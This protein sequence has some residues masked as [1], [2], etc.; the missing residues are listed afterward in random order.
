[1]G[2]KLRCRIG[3]ETQI[4]G[5]QTVLANLRK[6]VNISGSGRVQNIEPT[7]QYGIKSVCNYDDKLDSKFKLWG[8]RVSSL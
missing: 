7:V 6:L 8:P 3:S 1:M 5:S 4:S 2:T